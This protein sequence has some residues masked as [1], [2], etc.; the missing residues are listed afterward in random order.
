VRDRSSDATARVVDV[1]VES[2]DHVQVEVHYGLAGG[3]ACV[4]AYVVTVR[5]EFVVELGFD[6]VDEFEERELFFSGRVKPGFGVSFRD[7]EGVAGAD[8]I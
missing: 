2:R 3:F 6:L 7:D 1:A 8:G 4:E 5:V